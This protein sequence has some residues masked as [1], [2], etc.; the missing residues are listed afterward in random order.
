M[1]PAAPPAGSAGSARPRIPARRSVGPLAAQGALRPARTHLRGRTS[2]KSASMRARLACTSE[3]RLAPVALLH[4]GRLPPPPP[5]CLLARAGLGVLL[6]MSAV[7]CMPAADGVRGSR[8]K[9]SGRC[10]SSRAVAPRHGG[11]SLRPNCDTSGPA[12]HS[13]HSPARWLSACCRCSG[14]AA[15]SCLPPPPLPRPASPPP[16]ATPLPRAN[17]RGTIS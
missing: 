8:S 13:L 11:S 2:P 4:A 17:V 7:R 16:S 15:A 10:V 5:A 9:P 1:S 6:A 12:R 14:P 3:P